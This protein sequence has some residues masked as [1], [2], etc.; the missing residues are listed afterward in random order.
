MVEGVGFVDILLISRSTLNSTFPEA[1]LSRVS[2]SVSVSVAF[3][4]CSS[5]L[6]VR[7]KDTLL[8]RWRSEGQ[9][10][11]RTPGHSIMYLIRDA[12][13]VCF[14]LRSRPRR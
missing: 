6:L 13:V 8:W 11:A 4:T 7:S 14:D 9:D 2:V 1:L 12:C 10:A 5:S 3:I